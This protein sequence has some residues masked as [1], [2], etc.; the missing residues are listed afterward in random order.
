MLPGARRDAEV[1]V[2]RKNGFTGPVLITYTD[3][4][5][6]MTRDQHHRRGQDAIVL[7]PSR[8][9]ECT[10]I[11]CPPASPCAAPPRR[12]RSAPRRPSRSPSTAR[13]RSSSA[14]SG[15]VVTPERSVFRAAWRRRGR[16]EQSAVTKPRRTTCASPSP[17]CPRLASRASTTSS[18]VGHCNHRRGQP[19]RKMSW[20]VDSEATGL[21]FALVRYER[22][23][24]G[25]TFGTVS[26]DH[27]LQRRLG[28]RLRRGRRRPEQHRV[29]WQSSQGTR[30]RYRHRFRHR[31]LP[32]PQAPRPQ[33][34]RRKITTAKVASTRSR[35]RL[36]P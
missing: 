19:I 24:P 8:C 13:A 1:R 25:S 31:S 21:D 28:H 17:C 20:F 5:G 15:K 33:P 14:S 35:L 7:T 16:R 26:G 11:H 30:K 9:G 32:P 23:Q 36:R 12:R 18:W 34:W 10:L 2:V 27:V 4:P 6:G 29:G 22:W 3:L